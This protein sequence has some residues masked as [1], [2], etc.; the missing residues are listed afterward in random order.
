MSPGLYGTYKNTDHIDFKG[1]V[2][3]TLY[4]YGVE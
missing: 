4:G 3:K 2:K 1:M